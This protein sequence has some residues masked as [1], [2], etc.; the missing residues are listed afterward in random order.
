MS[1]KGNYRDNTVA[2]RFFGTLK[3]E[4]IDDKAYRTI[5]EARVSLFQYIEGFYNQKRRHSHPG[6]ISAAQFEDAVA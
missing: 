4:H 5:Q 6:N 1:R 3:T 2:E